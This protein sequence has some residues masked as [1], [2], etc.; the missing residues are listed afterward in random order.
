MI[1][2]TWHILKKNL[3]FGEMLVSTAPS[4]QVGYNNLARDLIE[5]GNIKKAES[6]I[7]SFCKI[8]PKKEESIEFESNLSSSS[9]VSA[10]S[11]NFV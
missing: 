4:E 6:V 1:Q 3:N 5:A 8:D 10:V 11:K 7:N 9:V 2:K